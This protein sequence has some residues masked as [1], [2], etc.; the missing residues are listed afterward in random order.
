MF[1]VVSTIYAQIPPD[2]KNGI[3]VGNSSSEPTGY[4][5]G[6]MY[7]NSADSLMYFYDGNRWKL[8]GVLQAL[9]EGNGIGYRYA[10]A[11]LSKMTDIG[12]NSLDLTTVFGG[13]TDYGVGSNGGFSF[14]A[15]NKLPRSA[16]NF[17]SHITMGFGNT[18]QGY[19]NNMAFGLSNTITNGYSFFTAGY[20]NTANMTPQIGQGASLGNFNSNTNYWNFNVGSGLIN[21]WKGSVAVGMGNVDTS[22]GVTASDRP[23]FIVGN[24]NLN[25]STVN[26]GQVLSRSDAFRVLANGTVEMGNDLANGLGNVV[27]VKTIDTTSA[28]YL[29]FTFQSDKITTSAN[30]NIT[31]FFSNINDIEGTATTGSVRNFYNSLD[32]NQ[33]STSSGVSA[34]HNSVR[35]QNGGSNNVTTLYNFFNDLDITTSQTATHSFVASAIH[36]TTID[37]PNLT[38]TNLYGTNIDLNV[39]DGTVSNILPLRIDIDQNGANSDIL[40]GAYITVDGGID[41]AEAE[42][43]GILVIESLVDL[44]SE[45]A[46]TLQ[47]KALITDTFTFATLPTGV[48]GMTATIT[49]ASAVSYRGVASGGGSDTALVF[50]D[51][52]QW[53][54]H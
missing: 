28:M 6:Q 4:K 36:S 38:V 46:G 17:G 5:M 1:L 10:N 53:I 34:I 29:P 51:G 47:A 32:I 20:E 12:A 21:K 22:E 40:D 52:T 25:S 31:Y 45:L 48:V 41:I 14:G 42:S 13:D 37:A 3:I 30:T 7:F 15:D 49:D 54:Y 2:F 16:S 24:G 26:Y 27:N 50:Y 9:D 39:Q 33:T 8:S 18:V 19:Y 44:P 23:I 43:N 11:D 35:Y